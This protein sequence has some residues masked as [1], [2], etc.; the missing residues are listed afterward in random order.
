MLFSTQNQFLTFISIFGV[1][2]VGAFLFD[3]TNLIWHLTSKNNIVK[4]IFNFL[5]MSLYLFIFFEVVLNFNYGEFRWFCFLALLAAVTLQRFTFGKL[6]AK[7]YDVWYNTFEKLKTK[8]NK[9]RKHNGQ[10]QETQN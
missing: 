9:R 5:A 8:L 3:I 1:M 6:I 4:N 7:F 10:D 2:F